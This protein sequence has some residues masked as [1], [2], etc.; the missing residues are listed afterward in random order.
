MEHEK[1]LSSSFIL[2]LEGGI[3]IKEVVATTHQAGNKALP[4]CCGITNVNQIAL[5]AQ[6][7]LSL[8]SLVTQDM[9]YW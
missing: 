4:C 2:Y 9:S 5:V 1:T 3:A 6:A 7:M 8:E